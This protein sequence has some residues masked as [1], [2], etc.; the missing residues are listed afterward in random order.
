MKKQ[1]SRLVSFAVVIAMMSTL[2]TP[3]FAAP[4]NAGIVLDAD[5]NVTYAQLPDDVKGH[6]KNGALVLYS[7]ETNRYYVVNPANME[8]SEPQIVPT[9]A[10]MYAPHGG[11]YDGYNNLEVL[12]MQYYLSCA[13]VPHDTAAAWLM[14][15]QGEEFLDFL[16]DQITISPDDVIAFVASALG[17]NVSWFLI[18]YAIAEGAL[19]FVSLAEVHAFAAAIQEAEKAGSGYGVLA[20][21]YMYAISSTVVVVY[22]TWEGI[23]VPA[24]Q[25]GGT[26]NPREYLIGGLYH[27]IVE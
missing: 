4:A 26:W 27:A 5:S 7:E 22:N 13:Y 17:I 9:E 8:S 2:M 16:R 23:Y 15:L 18:N 14:Q 6:V 20:E 1:I 3:A 21:T 10:R 24:L 12:P 11:T 25:G 19:E